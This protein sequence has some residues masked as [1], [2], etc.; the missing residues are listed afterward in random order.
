MGASSSGTNPTLSAISLSEPLQQ[1]GL[2]HRPVPLDG[3]RRDVERLRRFRNARAGEEPQLDDAAGALIERSQFGQRFVQGEHLDDLVL[4]LRRHRP[5]RAAW[6]LHRACTR[7]SGG[8]DRRRSRASAA[9]PVDER[10]GVQFPP[11]NP[12]ASP[13]KGV[14]KSARIGPAISGM[15]S[16]PAN[17]WERVRHVF[18]A[19]L[20]HPA[21]QRASFVAHSC[22]EEPAIHDQVAALLAWHDRAGDFLE[23]PAGVLLG[24]GASGDASADP[25]ST[26]ISDG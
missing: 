4:R 26:R 24:H 3:R 1:P 11:A 9:P 16:Q 19:A 20:L 7:V 17:N 14:S 2:C 12:G 5:D 21:E 6:G 10:V 25:A 18:E 13:R 15:P 23:T 22:R 8:R